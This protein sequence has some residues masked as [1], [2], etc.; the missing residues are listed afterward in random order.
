MAYRWSTSGLWNDKFDFVYRI[1][2]K[3]LLTTGWDRDYDKEDRKDELKCLIHYNLV[4]QGEVG[5]KLKEM[6]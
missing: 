1:T 6:P 4:A 3:T 2:L 5:V